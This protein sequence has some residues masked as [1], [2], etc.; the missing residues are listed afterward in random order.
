M[1]V[2]QA[3]VGGVAVSPHLLEEDFTGEHLAR[4]ARQ[5]DQQVEFEWCERDLLAAAADLVCRNVDHDVGDAQQFGRLLF[6]TAQAS[7]HSRHQLL[8]LERL[9]DVVVRTGFEAEHDVD[10]VGLG[11]QHHDGHAGIRTQNSAYVDPVHSGKHE[12]EQDEVGP[13]LTHC[14]ERQGSVAYHVGIETLT[15][16]HDREHLGECRVVVDNQN[17]WF[18]IPIVASRSDESDRYEAVRR[19]ASFPLLCRKVRIPAARVTDHAKSASL[20]ASSP[21][22]VSGPTIHQGETQSV[23]A[24]CL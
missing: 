1:H 11:R 19:A 16:Q 12:I 24:N 13:G 8:R 4:L 20:R 21:G 15:T 2:H 9:H 14:R 5:C 18:H 7:T 22:S 23:A 17:P 6:R 3:G 10:G